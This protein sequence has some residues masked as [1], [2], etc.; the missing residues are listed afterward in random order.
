MIDNNM[1]ASQ[2]AQHPACCGREGLVC[3][4]E[5][6]KKERKKER[7]G[8]RSTEG[9]LQKQQLVM[10]FFFIISHQHISFANYHFVCVFLSFSLSLSLATEQNRTQSSREINLLSFFLLS[11]NLCWE[12]IT[13]WRSPPHRQTDRQTDRQSFGDAIKRRVFKFSLIFQEL[14][15]VYTL[16]TLLLRASTAH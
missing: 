5:E 9:V 1:P 12:M 3:Q 11:P 16:L 4:K 7:K 10:F 2:P 14:L 6:R 15:H 13:P 8:S